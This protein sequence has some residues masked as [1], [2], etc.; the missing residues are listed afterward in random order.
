LQSRL[1]DGALLRSRQTI[2]VSVPKKGHKGVVVALSEPGK[3]SVVLA[4]PTKTPPPVSTAA[5]AQ[6]FPPPQ[7]DSMP[8]VA[9]K[10]AEAVKGAFYT[11]GLAP[12]G[13]HV[14]IYLNGAALADVTADRGGHWSMTIDKGMVGG[15]YQLRAD[16]VNPGGKVTARAEVPFEMP[17]SLK[18]K[19]DLPDSGIGT[20]APEVSTSTSGENA[21]AADAKPQLSATVS[22]QATPSHAVVQKIET[23][24]V[25]RGDSLWR[26]S[27]KVFGRGIRY[28]WIY[29][30]NSSQIRNPNLIYPGQ[31]FVLPRRD[32]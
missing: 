9:F 13:T 32:H 30:A 12:P 17:A 3:P 26:I 24:S 10:T 29:A 19:P 14:R 15:H 6:P 22:G 27:R 4:D 18:A 11:T 5:V 20:S 21:P 25:V 2:T 31:L 16:A 23:A 7:A 1:G 28:T 8:K